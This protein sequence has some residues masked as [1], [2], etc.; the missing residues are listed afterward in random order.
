MEQFA[1]VLQ[2]EVHNQALVRR[3]V[4]V[5]QVANRI[6]GSLL[7]LQLHK[8]KTG[9]LLEGLAEVL[10]LQVGVLSV[11]LDSLLSVAHDLD[12]SDHVLAADFDIRVLGFVSV[13]HRHHELL[14]F[15]LVEVL[16]RQVAQLHSLLR[17]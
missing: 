11:D 16:L 9:R 3:Q 7:V 1:S 4:H 15:R 14:Q 6:E 2:A 17:N 12:L 10:G 13:H 8:S 5:V